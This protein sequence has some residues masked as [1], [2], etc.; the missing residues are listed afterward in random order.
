MED[1]SISAK[2]TLAAAAPAAPLTIPLTDKWG[3]NKGRLKITVGLS[4]LLAGAYGVFSEQNFVSSSSAVVSAYVVVV[5]TP[6]D[7]VVQALPAAPN[8]HVPRGQNLGYVENPRVD[9][10][11]VENLRVIEE[12]DRPEAEAMFTEQASLRQQ[13]KELLVR[14]QAH[15]KA[16]SNR[17]QLDVLGDERVLLAK[18]A[19]QKQASLDLEQRRK[20]RESRVIAALT[21]FGMVIHTSSF[22]A[23][24]GHPGYSLTVFW[25]LLNTLL[26]FFASVVCVEPPKRRIDERF[27]TDEPASVILED[28]SELP[29]RF[30]DRSLGGACLVREDGW[31]SLVGPAS[32]VFDRGRMA[33]PFDVVRRSGKKLALKFRSTPALRRELIVHPFT[34]SHHRDAESVSIPEVAHA[35]AKVIVW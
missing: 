31:R 11:H 24:H 27:S 35:L 29:C 14:A 8:L 4:V 5:R 17:I 32:W 12:C 2:S 15:A 20:L 28:G 30:R 16:V 1:S 26:L 33:V 22:S 13:Q 3:M 21:L 34:G 23:Y 19:A 6:I 18:Q 25:S 9:Q 10:Q 7:G